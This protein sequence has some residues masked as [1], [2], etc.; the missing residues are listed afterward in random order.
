MT[1]Q[2]VT[3]IAVA[4]VVAGLGLVFP[5][6][7]RAQ[8]LDRGACREIKAEI[9]KL[10]PDLRVAKREFKQIRRALRAL[11]KGSDRWLAK[12]EDA[13]DA[14]RALRA[15]KREF[16]ALKQDFRHQGCGSC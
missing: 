7:A 11:P 8:C 1:R 13:K 6:P 12:R 4:V 10:K 16:R 5:S 3:A 15:V 2:F 9:T 14:K